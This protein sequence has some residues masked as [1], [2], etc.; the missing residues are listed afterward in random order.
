MNAE[1]THGFQCHGCEEILGPRNVRGEIRKACPKC[2]SRNIEP[3]EY[4]EHEKFQKVKD[5]SQSIGF[6]LELLQMQG[7]H[8]MVWQEGNA[9][10]E[11]ALIRRG[12]YE[13]E[14]EKQR[15]SIFDGHECIDNPD[16]VPEGWVPYGKSIQQMLAD[17]FH[18][19]LDVLDD[20]KRR[21]LEQIRA[22]AH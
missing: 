10:D 1:T 14:G 11:P 8:L 5:T 15:C 12:P 4:P 21:M 2:R 6:F 9:E 19:D 7:V 17:H 3:I 18:I 22:G 13:D 20:E 16:H